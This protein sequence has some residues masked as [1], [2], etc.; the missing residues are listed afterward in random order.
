MDCCNLRKRAHERFRRP[1]H[2][3]LIPD[4]SGREGG[5]TAT[6]FVGMRIIKDE[7]GLDQGIMPVQRHSIQKHHALG[8]D[9]YFHIFEFEDV[10]VRAR[11]NPVRWPEF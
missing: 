11:S 10:I 3:H 7:P 5:S 2:A 8:I 6:T 1:A 9:K 4:S